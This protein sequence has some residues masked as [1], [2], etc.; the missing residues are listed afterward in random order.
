MPFS[1]PL[2]IC[3]EFFF[4]EAVPLTGVKKHPTLHVMAKYEALSIQ[5]DQ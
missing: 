3:S 5:S 1:R 4:A 2:P